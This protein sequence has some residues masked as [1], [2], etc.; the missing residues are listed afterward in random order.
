MTILADSADIVVESPRSMRSSTLMKSWFWTCPPFPACVVRV[1]DEVDEDQ[2]ALCKALCTQVG[3][4]FEDMS[5]K[6][7][8]V[9]KVDPVELRDVIQETLR[10]SARA[11]SLLKAAHNLIDR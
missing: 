6:A 9:G 10:V 1:T 5:V 8:L 2:I 4:L 3:M 11:E 7:I